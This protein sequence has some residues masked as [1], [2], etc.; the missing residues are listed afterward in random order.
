[1]TW[2]RWLWFLLGTLPP[3]IKLLSMEGVGWSKA[4]GCMF[5]L[6]WVIN[7]FLIVF[8]MANQSFFTI[9]ET[10]RISWPGYEQTTRSLHHQRIQRVLDQLD[11]G[12]AIAVIIMHMVLMNG[13]FR[14]VKRIFDNRLLPSEILA[15][16]DTSTKTSN[17]LDDLLTPIWTTLTPLAKT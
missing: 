8:A 14:I 1:M 5:L 15:V 4:W 7:E 9:S 13:V 6:S 16:I 2:L 11:K 10:R 3:A 17:S 12:L